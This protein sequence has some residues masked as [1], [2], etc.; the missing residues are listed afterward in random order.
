MTA[1]ERPEESTLSATVRWSMMDTHCAVCIRPFA[2]SDE[3]Q[4]HAESECEDPCW[5][6]G[7][8]WVNQGGDCIGPPRSDPQDELSLWAELRALQEFRASVSGRTS[9]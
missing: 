4:R 9:E 8:C 1:P 7:Y 6:V 2:T 3:E 5:C